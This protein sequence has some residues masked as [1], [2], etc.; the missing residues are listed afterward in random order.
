MLKSIH[1]NV[2]VNHG[3]V[4]QDIGRFA[5]GLEAIPAQSKVFVDVNGLD[6]NGEGVSESERASAA[7]TI[8]RCLVGGTVELTFRGDQAEPIMDR[9]CWELGEQGLKL[10]RRSDGQH[11]VLRYRGMPG[12]GKAAVEVE[13]RGVVGR[14]DFPYAD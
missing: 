11:V 14:F 1:L 7:A 6:E 2:G 3:G 12:V 10:L 5:S 9:G 4:Q 8:Y 13:Q